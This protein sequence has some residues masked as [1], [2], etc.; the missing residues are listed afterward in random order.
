MNSTFRECSPLRI[1]SSFKRFLH[2]RSK[3]LRVVQRTKCFALNWETTCR[4]STCDI[5]ILLY[6]D[7]YFFIEILLPFSQT[8]LLA[9][10]KSVIKISKGFKKWSCF[11]KTGLNK[12]LI[13][14]TVR[15]ATSIRKMISRKYKF[16]ALK[17]LK[18]KM[19]ISLSHKNFF[20]ARSN[21]KSHCL[22]RWVVNV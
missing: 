7:L 20:L 10:F 5:R 16:H 19:L 17:D 4:F 3:V 14:S 11:R 1:R 9:Y 13:V 18:R 21:A 6:L 2:C 8:Y 12:S 22:F 15:T